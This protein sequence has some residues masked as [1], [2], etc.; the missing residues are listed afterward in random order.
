MS[1]ITVNVTIRGRNF[2]ITC[3][4]EEE[5]GIR[6]LAR[7]I[8]QRLKAM[9]QAAP[10]ASETQVS[11]LTMLTMAAELKKAEDAAGQT[12]PDDAAIKEQQDKIKAAAL[13]EAASAQAAS[14]AQML[15]AFRYFEERIT[16]IEKKLA[17]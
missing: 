6:D 12:A 16:S 4:R 9:Q 8:D 17:S 14:D 5:D 10:H 2:P 1:Q 3:S 13:S 15:E 7:D 11:I